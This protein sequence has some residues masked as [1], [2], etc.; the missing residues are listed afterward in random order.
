MRQH[1]S[2]S[3]LRVTT[4]RS[5][6]VTSSVSPAASSSARAFPEIASATAPAQYNH[7]RIPASMD[8]RIVRLIDNRRQAMRGTGRERIGPGRL[9]CGNTFQCHRYVRPRLNTPRVRTW[10]T[11]TGR[12]PDFRVAACLLPSRSH[13]ATSGSLKE[14]S[15]ATVAGA[16]AASIASDLTVFPFHPLFGRNLFR[17]LW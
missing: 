11:G 4:T 8:E 16:V 1:F 17:L 6:S 12:S 15:P 3:P 14:S 10:V 2:M 9:A 5:S 13:R 7:F